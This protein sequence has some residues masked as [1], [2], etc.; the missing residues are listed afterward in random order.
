MSILPAKY[1]RD[2]TLD[3][4]HEYI[5]EE[6]TGNGKKLYVKYCHKNGQLGWLYHCFSCQNSPGG[7]R[8]FYPADT[9]ASPSETID[10]VKRLQSKTS[11]Y[12]GEQSVRLPED[13][14]TF[15]DQQ[16]V[17]YLVKYQITL[18]EAQR[19]GIGYSAG[20]DRM[21]IPVYA[22]ERLVSYQARTFKLPYTKHNPKY[23]TVQARDVKHCVYR[24]TCI[25]HTEQL[26]LVEAALSVIKLGSVVDCFGL[27]GSSLDESLYPYLKGREVL[28]WLD[29][30]KNIE[31]IKF[32]KHLRTFINP[33]V[34]SILTKRKPKCYP[35]SV[36]ERILK[37]ECGL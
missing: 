8:G 26:V 5:H 16:A 29:P 7:L 34:K 30:D 28:I 10:M 17:K 37:G 36:V 2:R 3:Y 31:S 4:N 24:P 32:A 15:L 9:A 13:F 6:C 22:G 33:N 35:I 1:R 27:L 25:L 21:I 20:L 18:K 12:V 11:Q 19:Y 23:L 14:T